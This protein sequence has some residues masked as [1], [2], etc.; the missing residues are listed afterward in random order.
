MSLTGQS[1]VSQGS[2]SVSIDSCL[3]GPPEND[4]WQAAISI[5]GEPTVKS[6]TCLLLWV[7]T[8]WTLVDRDIAIFLLK[9]LMTKTETLGCADLYVEPSGRIGGIIPSNL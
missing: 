9:I 8:I 4:S 2:L 7:D 1:S 5:A 3:Q 6:V